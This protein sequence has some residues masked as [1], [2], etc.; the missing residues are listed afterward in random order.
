MNS[1]L[2]NLFM[3]HNY[4]VGMIYI[5]AQLFGFFINMKKFNVPDGH[6]YLI[7]ICMA[8]LARKLV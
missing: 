7:L 6:A 8:V 2:A 5:F 1:S 4:S 3:N